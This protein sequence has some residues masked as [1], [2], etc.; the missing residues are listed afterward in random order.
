MNILKIAK[1]LKIKKSESYSYGND[2]I[3]I[4]KQNGNK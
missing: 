1:K 2:F 3:K 4:K